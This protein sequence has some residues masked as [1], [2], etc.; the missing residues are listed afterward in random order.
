MTENMTEPDE[1]K[2]GRALEQIRIAERRRDALKLRRMGWGYYD[3]GREL[4]IGTTQAWTDVRSELRDIPADARHDLIALT[5]QQIDMAIS[6]MMPLVSQGDTT[7]VA[8]VIALLERRCRL[9][10][11]DAPTQIQ[12]DN[13]VD[14]TA[15]RDE[16]NHLTSEPDTTPVDVGDRA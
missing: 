8:K 7:A 15:L 4:G 14:L 9:F 3:I 2:A 1:R 5:N 10:G 16:L 6:A 13:G 11:L 12:V